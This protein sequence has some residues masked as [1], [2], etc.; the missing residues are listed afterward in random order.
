MTH[1]ATLDNLSVSIVSHGHGAMVERLV[2]QLLDLPEVVRIVVT[3]NI[4]E[5]TVFPSDVRVTVIDNP[6]LRALERITTRPSH[7]AKAMFTACSTRI[8][9]C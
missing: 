6:S 7:C 1:D 8:S 5:S 4:P 3:R 2:G 9:A